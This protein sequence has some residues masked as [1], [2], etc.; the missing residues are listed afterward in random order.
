MDVRGVAELNYVRRGQVCTANG[1]VSSR[2][3]RGVWS[4]ACPR[5]HSRLAWISRALAANS[6]Y[7]SMPCFVRRRKWV[8]PSHL[9]QLG[10]EHSMQLSQSIISCHI[11]FR[12]RRR[13]AIAP[14]QRRFHTTCNRALGKL[15][16]SCILQAPRGNWTRALLFILIELQAS[17][18]SPASFVSCFLKEKNCRAGFFFK[19]K[20]KEASG[21]HFNKASSPSALLCFVF[22][23]K[24]KTV[25]QDSF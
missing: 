10:T 6:T 17:P 4:T 15:C 21:A 12:W 1:V 13:D 18:A 25:E 23:E 2:F 20:T 5:Y 22:F 16:W 7:S 14:P 24:K 19:S 9:L 11:T 8:R 3:S